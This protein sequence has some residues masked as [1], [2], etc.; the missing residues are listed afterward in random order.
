MNN[1]PPKPLLPAQLSPNPNNK[2]G[3]P[4]MDV[5]LPNYQTYAISTLYCNDI[6][7]HSGRNIN[8]TTSPI[9]M[10]E[11]DEETLEILPVYSEDTLV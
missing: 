1:A 6:Q 2:V 5:E 9:I 3:K 10:E 11:E 4:V 7:S 8:K